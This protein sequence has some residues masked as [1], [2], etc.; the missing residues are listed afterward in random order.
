MTL[1]GQGIY[2][3]GRSRYIIMTLVGQGIYDIGRSRYI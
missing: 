1:E 3:I 2:D